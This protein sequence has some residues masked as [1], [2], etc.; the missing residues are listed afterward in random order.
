MHTR[1]WITA[2]FLAAIICA[3][4]GCG[5]GEATAQPA[6]RHAAPMPPQA[7]PPKPHAA[8]GVPKHATEPMVAL[9]PE[10]PDGHVQVLGIVM[11]DRGTGSAVQPLDS[12]HAVAMPVERFAEFQATA[13]GTWKGRVQQGSEFPMPAS[14]LKEPAVHSAGLKVDG[15]WS[16]ILPP[17]EYQLCLGNLGGQ[18]DDVVPGL[19]LWVQRCVQVTVADE[20]F[21]TIVLQLD[22]RTGDLTR[23]E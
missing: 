20:E 13:G 16:M 19:S 15:T 11:K 21:Q 22:G 17:G 1:A 4:A 23:L 7:D 9:P 12:G 2:S 6:P 18:A 3:A 14:L 5:A 10:L 8:Y